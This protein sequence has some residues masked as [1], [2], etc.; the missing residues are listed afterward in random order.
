M[1]GKF[2]RNGGN[3]AP[4]RSARLRAIHGVTGM[5]DPYTKI[6]ATRGASPSL[7]GNGILC[8]VFVSAQFPRL[9][10]R[11]H[12]RCPMVRPCLAAAKIARF[13]AGA[14][15]ARSYNLCAPIV[16][17][18]AKQ[19]RAQCKKHWAPKTSCVGAEGEFA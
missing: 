6:P 4:T 5:S 15:P 11:V 9:L 14:R 3:T 17:H 7:G 18:F 8:A 1:A 2:C 10:K 19:R 16:G 13:A 12:E